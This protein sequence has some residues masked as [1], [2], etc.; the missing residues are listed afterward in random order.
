MYLPQDA[1]GRVPTGSITPVR[2][3][4]GRCLLKTSPLRQLIPQSQTLNV[5]L[6]LFCLGT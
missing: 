2:A 5:R 3:Y 1:F 4:T 6:S